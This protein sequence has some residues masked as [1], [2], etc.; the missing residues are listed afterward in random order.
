[1]GLF[2]FNATDYYYPN[3]YAESGIRGEVA[4]RPWRFPSLFRLQF[5][6]YPGDD[7]IFE[8][9]VE[10][11]F[12]YL[13]NVGGFR[14]GAA[15]SAGAS[16]VKLQYPAPYFPTVKP[17]YLPWARAG[18]EISVGRGVT[19]AFSVRGGYRF[20]ALYYLG[21]SYG[22]FAREQGGDPWESVHMPFGEAAYRW[23]AAWAFLGRGGVEF[24][25]YYDTVFFNT[26]DKLRPFGEVGAAYTF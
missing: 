12:D 20:R 4:Y 24:G 25:G 21:S 22:R 17:Q 2:K 19:R 3:F 7:N 9:V 15:P 26:R 11:D 14:L 13:I 10:Y 23:N 16:L 1:M 18:T 5:Y 6:G 8:T